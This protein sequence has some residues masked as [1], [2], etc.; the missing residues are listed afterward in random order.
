M[1]QGL[2]RRHP[3]WTWSTGYGRHLRHIPTAVARPLGRLRRSGGGDRSS[4]RSSSRW[5]RLR[6]GHVPLMT[7]SIR[8]R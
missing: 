2:R 8:S 7:A 1:I 5:V 4:P 6:V 3:S